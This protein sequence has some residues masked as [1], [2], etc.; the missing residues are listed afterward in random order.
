[1]LTIVLFSKGNSNKQN[2]KLDKLRPCIIIIIKA[3]LNFSDFELS[4]LLDYII[5]KRV[6]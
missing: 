1:M 6:Y 5:I 3:F 2:L 4:C